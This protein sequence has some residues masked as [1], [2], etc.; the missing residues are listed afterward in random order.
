MAA[1]PGMQVFYYDGECRLCVGAVGILSRLDTGNRLRWTPYQSL[2][3]PPEGLSPADLTEAAWLDSG[4]GL[5]RGFYAFRE[6]ARRLLP[7]VPLTWALWLPGLDRLGDA[8]YR[9]IARNRYVV[10]RM[11]GARNEG[12]EP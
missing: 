6:M 9:R 11:L 7:F 12:T 10:S 4:E 1:G 5:Y 2:E 3:T 8:L